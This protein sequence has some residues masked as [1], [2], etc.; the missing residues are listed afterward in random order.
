MM[1]R[2]EIL[3]TMGGLKLF[4]V[5]AASDEI[6]ST[7]MKRQHEPQPV[8][9]DLLGA[10]LSEK[11]ARSIKDRVAIARL[12]FG[13]RRSRSSPS[14]APRSTRPGYATWSAVAS[15]STSAIS[16]W[17]AVPGPARPTSP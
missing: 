17:S 15:S 8:V 10:R 13:P 16:C 2:A 12:P 14:T 1:E 9:S 3:A 6:V 5:K 4:G 11:Q 7:A